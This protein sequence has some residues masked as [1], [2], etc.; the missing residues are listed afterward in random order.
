MRA[1]VVVAVLVGLAGVVFVLVSEPSPPGDREHD[2]LAVV[3]MAATSG[4]FY[5]GGTAPR[6]RILL[7][8]TAYALFV[9]TTMAW[10]VASPALWLVLFAAIGVA[11]E[12]VRRVRRS[13]E[14]R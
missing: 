14:P 11:I 9:A 10:F 12:A 3:A 5:A 2:W 1:P 6:R 4:V 8:G 13:A 7:V